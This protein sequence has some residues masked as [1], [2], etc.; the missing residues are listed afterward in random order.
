MTAVLHHIAWLVHMG[1]L[2]RAG[3]ELRHLLEQHRHSAQ[4]LAA[5]HHAMYA[6]NPDWGL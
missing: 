1:Y 4:A 3:L 6:M 5:I 2:N